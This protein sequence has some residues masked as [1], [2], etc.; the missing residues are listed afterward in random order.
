MRCSPEKREDHLSLKNP[1]EAQAREKLVIFDSIPEFEWT[2]GC[3]SYLN[4]FY[5]P[6]G[7]IRKV[8]LICVIVSILLV[9]PL[10]FKISTAITNPLKKLM[11]YFD[12]ATAG[13]SL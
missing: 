12:Q 2:V 5:E 4:E 13:I 7:T 10:T 1:D 9:L 8:F 3:S 11:Q 6:L